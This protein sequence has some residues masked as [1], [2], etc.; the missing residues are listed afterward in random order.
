MEDKPHIPDS[1]ERICNDG[2]VKIVAG[3][4]VEGSR[5]ESEEGFRGRCTT[6]I[7]YCRYNKVFDVVKVVIEI[8]FELAVS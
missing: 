1:P 8:D 3:I 5:R 6:E 4:L 7:R 2:E